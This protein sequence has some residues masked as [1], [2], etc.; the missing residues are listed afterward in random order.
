MKKSTREQIKEIKKE[1]QQLEIIRP[2]KLSKQTRGI[3]KGTYNYLSYTFQN[4]GATDYIKEKHVERVNKEVEAFRRFKY[5]SD[6]W[7]KLSIKLSKQEM[8]NN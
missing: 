8:K 2:G 4:K 3:K 6:E 5:L 7:I 1:I